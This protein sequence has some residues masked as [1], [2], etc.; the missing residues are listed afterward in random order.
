MDV[1]NVRLTAG[2][3]QQARQEVLA[4]WPTGKEVN[5][6]EAIEYQ[7]TLPRTKVL[8]VYMATSPSMLP[9]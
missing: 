5:L 3:F 6:E 7:K 2:E 9:P 1:R 8:A 4:M